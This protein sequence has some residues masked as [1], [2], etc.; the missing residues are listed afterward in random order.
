M[1][2]LMRLTPEED[3][4]I[5]ELARN[6]A[7]W[8]PAGPDAWERGRR[9]AQAIA[10][11]YTDEDWRRV[12]NRLTPRRAAREISNRPAEDRGYLLGLLDPEQ[13]AEVERLLTVTA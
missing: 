11:T 5:T 8:E 10:D 2:D 9:I 13:R 1:V 12:L 4:R 7:L 3:E 6:P